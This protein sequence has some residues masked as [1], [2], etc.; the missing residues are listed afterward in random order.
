[1][2]RLIGWSLAFLLFW[3]PSLAGS[4][5]FVNR[6]RPLREAG[7]IHVG[8]AVLYQQDLVPSDATLDSMRRLPERWR[9]S[10]GIY[11]TM[12]YPPQPRPN[13]TW[14]VRL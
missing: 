4:E 6:P 10:R 9:P 1:M 7:Q 5:G 11:E 8:D 13:S 14:G 2:T 12:G 3:F